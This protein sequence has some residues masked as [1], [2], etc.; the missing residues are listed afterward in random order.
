M[1]GDG[2][3]IPPAV[4]ECY[5]VLRP[6]GAMLVYKTFAGD[7]LEPKEAA[8]LYRGL[9]GGTLEE[10]RM[11]HAEAAFRDA[12]FQIEVKDVIG[13]EGREYEVEHGDYGPRFGL[14]AS[15]LLRRRDYFVGKYGAALFEQALADAQWLPFIMLGKL[16]P[17]AYLLRK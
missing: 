5:R 10:E 4:R 9:G 7:L 2:F 13:G 6:G 11:E 17:V 15:R 3:P 14:H 8:R 12:G 1:L 16:L